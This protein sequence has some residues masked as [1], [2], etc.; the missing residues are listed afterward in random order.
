MQPTQPTRKCS[1][2]GFWVSIA[3][4][5]ALVLFS[6][7]VN[8]GL[9]AALVARKGGAAGERGEDEF[10]RLTEKWSYGSGDVKAVRIPVEGV[11]FRETEQG[12]FGPRYD[13]IEAILRQVRAA[14]S[15]ED[16]KAVILEVDS[17]GGDLTSSDEIYQALRNFKV[18]TKGRKVVALVRNLAASGGYYVAMPADWI[19]AEPTALVGSIGVILQTL[20]WKGLSEKIGVTDT[21][22][23]S[24]AN[25]DLLNPFH[26]VAPE[27]IALLQEVIDRMHRRFQFIVGSA[28]KI[29]SEKLDLLAD[30]RIFT[31]DA[32]LEHDLIDQIG[33]FDDAV[34]KTAELLGQPSVKVIRYEHRTGFFEFLEQARF[35]LSRSRLVEAT[36]PRL[37]YLW[38][39]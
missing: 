26:D 36:T 29:S 39:P 21:T 11:I 6:L 15:D 35:P 1:H 20:N 22:I 38:K 19:I 32:S 3:L 33:Y 14:Q 7:V 16:V 10:P 25:K 8:A 37:M 24:G 17:P 28:R 30:G 9:L 31:A 2:V 18:S 27:Q 23:K 4:L 34:A 5:A 12:L 13:K